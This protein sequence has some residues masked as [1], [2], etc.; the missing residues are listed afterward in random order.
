MIPSGLRKSGNHPESKGVA[1]NLRGQDLGVRRS[2]ASW[3]M[4]PLVGAASCRDFHRLGDCAEGGRYVKPLL[5]YGKGLDM[6]ARAP[7]DRSRLNGP[8]YDFISEYER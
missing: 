4:S 2:P 7:T 1:G 5:N 6:E 3:D 8:P